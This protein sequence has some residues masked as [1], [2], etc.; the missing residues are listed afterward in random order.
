VNRLPRRAL[1]LFAGLVVVA[2]ACASS[3]AT[4]PAGLA[5]IGGSGGPG[6][7]TNAPGASAAFNPGDPN[8]IIS[9][10]IAGGP[11]TKSFHLKIEVDGTI[12][13]SGLSGLGGETSSGLTGDLKL[14]G[15]NIE[16]DVD[17]ANQAAHLAATVSLGSSGSTVT[18]PADVILKDAALYYK[19]DLP[20]LSSGK[21]TKSSVGD[22]SSSLTG[23]AVSVP[24]VGPSGLAGV[25]DQVAQIRKALDDAGATAKLV[26]VDKIG[27]Q[28]AYHITIS[29]PLDLIN[30]KIAGA[31][32]SA[33]STAAAG[34]T[35]DSA[36]VDI[37]VYKSGNR[38][39][40]I[41]IKA[42]SSK[43][44]NLDVVVTV[45]DYDKP[46]TITAPPASQVETTA[47]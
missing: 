21:Y 38:L 9:A 31:A 28:D 7:G 30:S 25:E 36:A 42:A 5:P 10:V 16:G 8:S 39:A 1:A 11:D 19:I 46:V 13:A 15:S 32:A 20:G 43:I 23:G 17:L 44:G 27:G 14:D 24:T 29:V 45:T 35:I 18:V 34:I 6:G 37:W 33:E 3:S 2:G 22:L 26:G 4:W 40:K 41:E 47:P 12:K